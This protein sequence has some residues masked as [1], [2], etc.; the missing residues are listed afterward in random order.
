[1]KTSKLKPVITS[2]TTIYKPKQSDYGKNS[3]ENECLFAAKNVEQE[4]KINKATTSMTRT[5]SKLTVQSK[6]KPQINVLSNI[7]NVKH[8]H[9]KDRLSDH[10]EEDAGMYL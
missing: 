2:V 6:S 8:I 3:Q 10:F 7:T 4:K 5:P 1:M 9:E